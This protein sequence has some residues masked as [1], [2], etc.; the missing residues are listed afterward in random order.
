MIV[1]LPGPGQCLAVMLIVTAEWDFLT[2]YRRDL[3]IYLQLTAYRRSLPLTTA[4]ALAEDELAQLVFIP[5][6]PKYSPNVHIP[7]PHP[8][9]L[10]PGPGPWPGRGGGALGV[11]GSGICII[12]AVFGCPGIKTD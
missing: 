7:Q 1:L 2:A 11:G 9:G 4:P 3:R 8:R 12:Y 10:G 6:Y 5:G